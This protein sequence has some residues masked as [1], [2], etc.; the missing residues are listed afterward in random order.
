MARLGI[1]TDAELTGLSEADK[2]VFREHTIHALMNSGELHAILKARPEIF[3]EILKTDAAWNSK[4]V[5]DKA[6]QDTGGLLNQLKP[7]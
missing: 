5:Y 6:R 4:K 2:D 7:K 1:Y 3:Q